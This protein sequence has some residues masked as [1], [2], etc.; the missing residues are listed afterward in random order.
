LALN[1]LLRKYPEAFTPKHVLWMLF[2]GNDL[3]DGYG[4]LHVPLQSSRM[5]A[6]LGGT[7]IETLARIPG[8]L[9][10]ESVLRQLTTGKL[11]L[12]GPA[13]ESGK[14][15]HYH[16]DGQRLQHPLYHSARFGYRLF[17]PT[18]IARAARPESY[19]MG[20]P[21]RELLDETFRKMRELS[22]RAGFRVTVLLT[23][24]AARL[25]QKYF[26][27]MPSASAEPYFIRYVQRLSSGMGFENVDLHQLLQPQTEKELLYQRDDSHWNER[28]NAVVA[29]IIAG[30]VFQR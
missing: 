29:E 10:E 8:Q 2:E 3:E 27:D 30:A 15:G 26:E 14:Q 11:K 23:P 20:H 24:S 13:V 9:R 1:Y 7:V 6:V 25:Y 18:Y 22:K 5:G 12:R 19:V 28:G 4:N 16:V 17:E 21:H